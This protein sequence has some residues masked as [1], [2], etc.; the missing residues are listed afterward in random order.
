MVVVMKEEF[1][2]V[3]VMVILVMVTIL[4]KEVVHIMMD[5]RQK[6]IQNH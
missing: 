1:E 6:V 2:I 3:I 4:A 5:G